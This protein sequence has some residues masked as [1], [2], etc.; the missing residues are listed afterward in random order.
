VNVHSGAIAIGIH[1]CLGTCLI[2]L[3]R[4][5]ARQRQKGLTTLCIGGGMNSLCVER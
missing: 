5:E 1:R 2:T 3:L 4:D